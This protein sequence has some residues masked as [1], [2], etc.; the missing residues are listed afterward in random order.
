MLEVRAAFREIPSSYQNADWTGISGYQWNL[1]LSCWLTLLF[2]DA[3]THFAR[4]NISFTACNCNL[5]SDKCIFSSSLY[6][7]SGKK[8]G[9]VCINCRH[10]TAGVNCQT[11]RDGYYRNMAVPMSH[12]QAC[13]GKSPSH[14]PPPI[15]F[16]PHYLSYANIPFTAC[17]CNL[18]SKK[19]AFSNSLY[20]LSGKLSGGI[21]LN[22]RHNTAGNNCHYC[23][24]GYYRDS[25][26][27][28]THRRACKG[29]SMSS[30]GRST[31]LLSSLGSSHRHDSVVRGVGA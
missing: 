20:M 29:N 3:I 27:P 9:G 21:C 6:E 28:I 15:L 16:L 11:C 22:C 24:E 4:C 2:Y 26:R 19:C 25:S 17:N 23:K 30:W 1:V 8:S 18:H 5:H 14:N 10:N 31:H 13:R 12:R 7:N